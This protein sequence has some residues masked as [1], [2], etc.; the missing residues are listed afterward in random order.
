MKALKENLERKMGRI[1]LTEDPLTTR[2]KGYL[3]HILRMMGN[4]I[5]LNAIQV[6][7]IGGNFGVPSNSNDE[8]IGKYL[9]GG[10]IIRA[11]YSISDLRSRYAQLY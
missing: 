2:N 6:N 11:R 4:H 3:E 5:Y 1:V 9:P 7:S 8:P 10:V